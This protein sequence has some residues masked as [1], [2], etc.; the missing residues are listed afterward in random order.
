MLNKASPRL[1]LI[2]CIRGITMVSMIIYHLVW[3]LVFLYGNN[4]TWFY[5]ARIWQQSICWTFIILSGF[6]WSLGRHHLKRGIIVFCSGLIITAVTVIIMP[7]TKIIFG[8]LTL[9]GSCI[10]IMIPLNKFLRK[11][12]TLL[13]LILSFAV[14]LFTKNCFN[15]YLGFGFLKFTLPSFL[16]K[17]YLTAFFGFP[18]NSFYSSDYFPLIPWFFLYVFGYFLFRLLDQKG[19]NQKFF[20]KGQIPVLNLLGKYSLIVYMLHQP[21]IYGVCEIIKY[22]L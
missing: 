17:N 10:L 13:G 8:I 14:F 2:D 1:H 9:L 6:S 12:P 7:S 11:V 19:L 4:W 20:S 15:G 21:V 5:K 3:D 22:I 16:Y 18:Q